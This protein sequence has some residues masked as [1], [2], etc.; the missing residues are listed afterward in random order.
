MAINAALNPTVRY[1][2]LKGFAPVTMLAYAPF[3]LAGSPQLA[4]RAIA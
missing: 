4:A 2:A 3:V 1:D